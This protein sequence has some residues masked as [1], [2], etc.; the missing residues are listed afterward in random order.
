M[1][2]SGCQAVPKADPTGDQ[3][4]WR[5]SFSRGEL[6]LSKHVPD[7]ARIAY[8]VTKLLWKNKLKP[9]C[10]VLRSYHLK[11]LFYHFLERTK[12]QDL[13]NMLPEL[14]VRR[15]LVFIETQLEARSCPHFFISSVNLF[16]FTTLP[17]YQKTKQEL[18]LCVT[19]IRSQT[20][21]DLIKKVF[22][23]GSQNVMKIQHIKKYKIF[24]YIVSVICLIILNILSICP[25]FL[26]YACG[27]F[28]LFSVFISFLYGAIVSIPVIILGFIIF[29]IFRWI[30]SHRNDN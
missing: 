8:V 20:Q 27:L 7:E 15:L 19:I 5:L 2:N 18:D 28:S 30:R 14:L 24:H 10:S 6:L 23:I 29:L 1:V 3:F 9:V 13:K 12:S 21:T 16:D 11:T 4:S 22:S 26:V 17:N 25:A